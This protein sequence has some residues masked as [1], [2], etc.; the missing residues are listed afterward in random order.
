MKSITHIWL[1]QPLQTKEGR[2]IKLHAGSIVRV[3]RRNVIEDVTPDYRA[4]H[5]VRECFTTGSGFLILVEDI[6]T[7]ERQNIKFKQL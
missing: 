2:T 7:K 5:I 4:T 6:V 3:N 1:K